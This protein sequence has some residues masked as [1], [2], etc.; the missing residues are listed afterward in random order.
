M[1]I[2]DNKKHHPSGGATTKTAGVQNKDFFRARM[3]A[4]IPTSNIQGGISWV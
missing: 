1:I 3:P 2:I 4:S